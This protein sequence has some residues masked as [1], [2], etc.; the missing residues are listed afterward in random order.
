MATTLLSCTLAVSLPS[1]LS[2]ASSHRADGGVR[3]APLMASSRGQ[4]VQPMWKPQSQGTGRRPARG[5]VCEVAVELGGSRSSEGEERKVEA[6][7]RVRVLGPLKVFHVPKNPE[8]DIGGMEGE[9]KEIVTTFKGKPVS[10]TFP[11]K[12]QLVTS[13]EESRKFFVHLKD[14]EF[15][16]V[17]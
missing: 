11:Y 3:L 2:A 16:V 17:E 15:E 9:V 14:D 4:L 13:G 10:A 1:L 7:A 12:V 6:G 8:F 5:V